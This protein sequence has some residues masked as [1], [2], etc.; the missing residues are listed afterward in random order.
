MGAQTFL[1]VTNVFASITKAIP[2][3][4]LI[5]GPATKRISGD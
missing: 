4:A 5:I 2:M 3:F 1:I